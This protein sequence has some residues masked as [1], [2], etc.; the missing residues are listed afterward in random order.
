MRAPRGA[1]VRL[2]GRRGADRFR[3]VGRSLT[4]A[5]GS[6]RPSGSSRSRKE[7]RIGAFAFT[8][9]YEDGTPA[10]PPTLK[11]VVP[12]WSAGY[13][14]PLGRDRMLRAVEIGP[15]RGDDDEPVLVVE[16]V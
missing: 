3:L 11:A 1:L 13:T 14:I 9:E 2:G 15:A 12:N 8:L 4:R 7:N 10:D 16:P 5:I 6:V